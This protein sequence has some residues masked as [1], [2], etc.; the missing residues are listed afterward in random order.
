MNSS[1][2][3]TAIVITTINPPSKAVS[4]FAEQTN[5][6]LI[7]VGDR[8]SPSDWHCPGSFYCSLEDQQRSAFSLAR[9]LPCD[10]Y[11]RKMVGYLHA[12]ADGATVIVDTDDDNVP[13][14][15]WCFPVFDGCFPVVSSQAGW[16]NIYSGFTSRRIW[17]RGFPLD[18]IQDPATLIE[19]KKLE[20]RPVRVGVWQGLADADPDVDAIYR[21]L[22]P[23][24]T[25]FED[26][27]PVVL[28]K[29]VFTPFNSQNTA[30]R[31]EAFPLL[32]LPT[33]VSFRYTD[34][35]RSYVA[36]PVL[37]AM[38]LQVG[39][40]GATVVQER[41]IHN[42]MKDFE[43]E[44]PCYRD[45]YRVRVI[46]EKTVSAGR[47]PGENVECI[48][49]ELIHHGLV[50]AEELTTLRAWLEDLDSLSK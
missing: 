22:H 10:H 33:S 39:V 25:W 3:N 27:A 19:R 50:P 34:M 24:E 40:V 47:S 17:P 46:A 36:Q 9:T 8:K 43:S 41:N 31:Q 45:V 6:H 30:F 26:L 4:A 44:I 48:Y 38:G 21:M 23:E 15:G 1:P 12:I 32:Y 37:W 5:A 35:L 29:E 7:V 20:S 49:R 2:A 16:V 11:G 14:P 18:A 42:L 13:K 28:G